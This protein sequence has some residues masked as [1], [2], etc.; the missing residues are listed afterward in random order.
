MKLSKNMKHRNYTRKL[1]LLLCGY[2]AVTLFGCGKSN[3]AQERRREEEAQKSAESTQN[4]PGSMTGT[5]WHI[6]WKAPDP[7][8]PNGPLITVMIADAETGNLSVQDSNIH[9]RLD[10]VH[11]QLFRNA[12]LAAKVQASEVNTDK[13]SRII[14]GTGGVKVVSI[15]DPPD[16]VITADRMTW[17]TRSSK[18]IA[19][20]N[21]HA[22]QYRSQGTLPNETF[23]D[24]ILFDT[25]TG[26][27]SVSGAPDENR[28]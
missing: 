25:E 1:L 26:K 21:A 11:A 20:G 4:R 14:V 13:H 22:I 27:L 3:E 15:T 8:H 5:N 18:V 7:K 28:K 19:E 17:D 24:R 10:G 16:T 12:R 6:P 23:G 9:L 2:I